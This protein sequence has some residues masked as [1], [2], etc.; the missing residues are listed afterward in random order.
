MQKP[1]LVHV[2]HNLGTDSNGLPL[3]TQVPVR[4]YLELDDPT[5]A[6][7]YA[8]PLVEE[9]FSSPNFDFWLGK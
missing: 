7:E 2:R 9:G 3:L 8:V 5:R 1:K 4:L 6:M